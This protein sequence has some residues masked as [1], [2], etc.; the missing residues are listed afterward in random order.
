MATDFV[1]RVE[2]LN[3]ERVRRISSVPEMINGSRLT[4]RRREVLALLMDGFSHEEICDELGIAAGSLK[5]HL[6]AMLQTTNA[7][8]KLQLAVWAARANIE[9]GCSAPVAWFGTRGAAPK[10]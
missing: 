1:E 2:Q 7:R 3:V 8:N 4:E 6:A 9:E 5:S 10:R